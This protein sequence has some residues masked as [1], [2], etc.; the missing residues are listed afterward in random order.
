MMISEKI[1]KPQKM[2]EKD[3]R[4]VGKTRNQ[5]QFGEIQVE[6]EIES[7]NEEGDEE[8]P[9][10]QAIKE[11]EPQMSRSDQLKEISVQES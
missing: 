1:R 7:Q 10:G 8:S 2:V 6:T 4:A 5:I 11:N 3:S 9:K